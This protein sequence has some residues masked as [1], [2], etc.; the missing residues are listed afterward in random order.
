MVFDM[1]VRMYAC[2]WG[3]LTIKDVYEEQNI[4]S[5]SCIVSFQLSFL[6]TGLSK[7]CF[8]HEETPQIL[9]RLNTKELKEFSISKLILY[10][11]TNNNV[12]RVKIK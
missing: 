12:K 10:L 8:L 6:T 11:V 1:Y 2:L 4:R 9:S 7:A 5:K 3:Q